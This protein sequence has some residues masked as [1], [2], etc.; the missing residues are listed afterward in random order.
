MDDDRMK[1]V[2]HSLVAFGTTAAAI[3]S[4]IA[5]GLCADPI[6]EPP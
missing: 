6:A 5:A 4:V 1:R 2:C 3:M